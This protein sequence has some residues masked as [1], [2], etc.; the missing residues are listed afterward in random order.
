LP[1]SDGPD[2]WI[3]SQV[4]WTGSVYHVLGVIFLKIVEAWSLMHFRLGTH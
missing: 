1:H 2:E 3:W 4:R